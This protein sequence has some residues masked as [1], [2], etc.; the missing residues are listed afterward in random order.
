MNNKTCV[1]R[2]EEVR[3]L[4]SFDDVARGRYVNGGFE[5]VDGV[6]S[7][8]GVV[9]KDCLPV[10]NCAVNAHFLDGSEKKKRAGILRDIRD[11]AFVTAAVQNHA[12]RRVEMLLGDL[13]NDTDWEQVVRELKTFLMHGLDINNFDEGPEHGLDPKR[14]LACMLEEQRTMKFIKGLYGA[15]EAL[16]EGR[17]DIEMVDAGCGPVL[18][19]GILAALRS[20]KTMVTCLEINEGSARMAVKIIERLRLENRVKVV[21]CDATKYQ[22]PRPID[23]LVSETMYSGLTEEPQAQIFGNLAPQ[24]VDDGI[25]MPESISVEAGLVSKALVSLHGSRFA[26]PQMAEGCVYFA[27]EPVEVARLTRSNLLKTVDGRIS[28]QGVR[29]GEYLVGLR[30]KIHVHGN[31]TVSGGDSRISAPV[32]P[33]TYLRIADRIADTENNVRVRYTPGVAVESIVPTIE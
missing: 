9:C 30:S 22:H 5:T 24:V 7:M 33:P 13:E 27:H 15:L 18:L 26:M 16:D 31:V 11:P 3:Y 8:V 32:L 2:G 4:G 10:L 25:V 14:A 21:N 23:L 6:R 12:R 17:E 29:P 1:I 20:D 28:T 19:F